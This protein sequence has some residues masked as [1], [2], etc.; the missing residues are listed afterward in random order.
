[1]NQFDFSIIIPT[2]DRNEHLKLCLT[3]ISNLDYDH[4]G[5]EVIVVNDGDSNPP[6]EVVASF[7]YQFDIKLLTQPHSGPAIARNKGGL[8]ARGEYLAFTDDDCEPS[9][10]WLTKLAARFAV[11]ADRCIGGQTMNSQTHSLHSL[12]SQ[13]LLQYLFSYYNAEPD[14]ARFLTSNNLAL[15]RKYF[16]EIGGFNPNF[17]LAAAEDRELCDRCLHLGYALSFAPEVLVYHN[18]DLTLHSFLKQHFNY[19]RGAHC[20]HKERARRTGTKLKLESP[21]FYL[22]LLCYPL[23]LK[24]SIRDLMIVTLLVLSQLSNAAGFLGQIVLENKSEKVNKSDY[25]CK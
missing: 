25:R 2:Y 10:D 9:P 15:P 1:M 13:A 19:G 11:R 18:Q 3:A 5:F 17:S 14:Q 22:N 20:F 7:K 16:L 24:R 23:S 4:N 6:Q 12:A 21:T 8:Q